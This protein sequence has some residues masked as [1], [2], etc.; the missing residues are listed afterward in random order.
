MNNNQV[1]VTINDDDIREDD[2]VFFAQLDAQNQP[3]VTN[4]DLA[5]VTIIDDNDRKL[6]DFP[7]S[8]MT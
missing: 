7:C 2:E 6:I 8:A 1:S 4:P 5:T 3:V